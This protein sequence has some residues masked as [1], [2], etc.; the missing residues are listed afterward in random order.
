[1]KAI[2]IDDEE[3]GTRGLELLLKR[4]CPQITVVDIKHSAEDGIR[5][6]LALK[7]ELMF[8]DIELPS[9]TGF[10]VIEAT[11]NLNYQVIFTTAYEHYALKAIKAQAADYLLKP[12]DSEEL[13]KAVKN[14]ET[15]LEQREGI[16]VQLQ[17]LLKATVTSGKKIPVPTGKGITLVAPQE[18]LYL[19][20]DSNYTTLHLKSG[21]KL[22]ISKTLKHFEDK[23]S[24][25]QFCRVHAAY[26]VNLEEIEHYVRGDGGNLI[27]KDKTSIP[28]SRMH[29]QAVLNRLGL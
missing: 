16:D 27:L 8:L 28:V 15:R 20:S 11:Q 17:K 25:A 24:P 4:H 19:Q 5:S 6:I 23:L 9:A 7:P 22:L 26:L 21:Q 18:I 29:K 10:D 3:T 12:I 1:M 13:I 14:A 2:I